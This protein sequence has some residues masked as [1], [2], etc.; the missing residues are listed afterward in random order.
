MIYFS[1]KSES[2]DRGNWIQN[3]KIIDFDVCFHCSNGYH[4]AL[5]K[6]W[7]ALLYH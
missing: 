1:G 4:V 7:Y 3:I 2:C 6:S 5:F